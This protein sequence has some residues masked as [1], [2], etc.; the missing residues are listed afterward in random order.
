MWI[1]KATELGQAPKLLVA[2]EDNVMLRI[3]FVS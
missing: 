3:R 1:L 2:M